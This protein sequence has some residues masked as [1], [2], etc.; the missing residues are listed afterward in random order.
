MSCHLKTGG[1]AEAVEIGDQ[2][3]EAGSLCGTRGRAMRTT[4]P[5]YPARGRFLD[6]ALCRLKAGGQEEAMEA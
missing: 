3:S 2:V 1:Y 5:R 6:L 4:L